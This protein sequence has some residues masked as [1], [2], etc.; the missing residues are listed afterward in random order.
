MRLGVFEFVEEYRRR[1]GWSPLPAVVGKLFAMPSAVREGE[2]E[3]LLE[4]GYLSDDIDWNIGYEDYQRNRE[5]WQSRLPE[6]DW[7]A[8]WKARDEFNRSCG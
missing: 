3:H 5:K 6:I 1:W 7:E 2:M 4:T 8:V